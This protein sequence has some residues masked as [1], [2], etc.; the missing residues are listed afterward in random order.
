MRGPADTRLSTD[1]GNAV[2][3]A[4]ERHLW[5]NVIYANDVI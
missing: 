1:D 2:T 5:K 3:Y 4:R